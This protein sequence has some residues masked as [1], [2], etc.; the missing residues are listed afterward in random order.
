M[1]TLIVFCAKYLFIAS[2]ALYF[3]FAYKLWRTRRGE[4]KSFLLT[5][6]F[7]FGLAYI[8]AKISS[9]FFYNARPFVVEH[10]AP[11]IAH[12]ADNG[13][14]SDHTLITMAIASVIFIYQ[15]K[16]GVVLAAIALVVGAARVLAHVHHVEDIVGSTVI[17]CI[18]VAAISWVSRRYLTK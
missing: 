9:H 17:A 14:P 11:L 3:V 1:N 4:L 6:I 15:R 16:W 18:S 13:F 8:V 10:I 12:A 7:S 2:L 5:T